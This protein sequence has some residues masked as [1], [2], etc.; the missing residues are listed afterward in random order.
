MSLSTPTPTSLRALAPGVRDARCRLDPAKVGAIRT[1]YRAGRSI[2]A[3]GRDFGV[4]PSTIYLVLKRRIWKHVP[5]PLGPIAF[6]TPWNHDRR[7]ITKL[8]WDQV[9]LIRAEAEGL[10]RIGRCTILAEKWGISVSS[11]SKLLRGTTWPEAERPRGKGGSPVKKPTPQ[12]VKRAIGHAAGASP[13][14]A[15]GAWAP[16]WDDD[17]EEPEA[18]QGGPAGPGSV[19]ESIRLYDEAWGRLEA[20]ARET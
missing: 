2:R 15:G 11:M 9:E 10:P 3:I 14:S 7:G 8:D 1:C 16:T 19:R 6:R 13:G 17:A 20:P 4:N 12:E 18:G 5:D